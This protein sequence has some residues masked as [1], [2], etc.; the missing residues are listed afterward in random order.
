M[1]PCKNSQSWSALQLDVA[2]TECPLRVIEAANHQYEVTNRRGYVIPQ[3]DILVEAVKK[4]VQVNGASS[5]LVTQ[6]T[7]ADAP[8]NNRIFRSLGLDVPNSASANQTEQ[9][10]TTVTH[11]DPIRPGSINL[12]YDLKLDP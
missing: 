5:H 11:Q 1:P 10:R 9:L 8:P 12:S 2:A 6:L 3:V 4:L 7:L